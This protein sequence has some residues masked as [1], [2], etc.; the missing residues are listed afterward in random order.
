MS[1]TKKI[2]FSVNKFSIYDN[3]VYK[4]KN[5]LHPLCQK[6]AI[7]SH[8]YSRKFLDLISD[9]NSE[10]MV[11]LR[12]T[13]PSKDNIDI[14]S[15]CKI[16]I[17]RAS[18]FYGFCNEHDSDLFSSFE[19]NDNNKVFYDKKSIS[20][21]LYRIISYYT[22]N[23]ST[24]KDIKE[25]AI[26]E[27]SKNN[28]NI[29][30]YD[31]K[32]EE[33]LIKESFDENLENGNININNIKKYIDFPDE[34]T[35]DFKHFVIHLDKGFHIFNTILLNFKILH[36]II[37]YLLIVE[38]DFK[39]INFF[40]LY[41]DLKFTAF[42]NCLPAEEGYY[43]IFSWNKNMES[44]STLEILIDYIQKHI[45]LDFFKEKL[46][47][48]IFSFNLEYP[49]KIVFPVNLK[50]IYNYSEYIYFIE[51]LNHVW[52]PDKTILFSR[53]K[54]SNLFLPG[55]SDLFRNCK[56]IKTFKIG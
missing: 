22:Y 48:Y 4:K 2:L 14:P 25:W 20:D 52:V 46:L 21:Y 36:H 23:H 24:Q 11:N 5:C 12:Q 7:R 33:G 19:K 8:L 15:S 16:H 35:K 49:D 6:K 55:Y 45:T 18:R 30:S 10:V 38:E 56:I 29:N 37:S 42:L 34:I 53:I 26:N 13:I 3:D 47:S 32:I 41:T 28:N 50:S 51:H 27:I 43:I 40:N 54:K 17:N 44:S 1:E 31:N 9:E 39:N